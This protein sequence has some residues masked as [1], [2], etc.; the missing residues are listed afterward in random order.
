[1]EVGGRG[2]A[3]L[4]DAPAPLASAGLV[5]EP[6]PVGSVPGRERSTSNVT[7]SSSSRASLATDASPLAKE[8]P[9]AKLPVAFASPATSAT[10]I[11]RAQVVAS[12]GADASSTDVTSRRLPRNEVAGGDTNADSERDAPSGEA[13]LW[14]AF[15]GM[16]FDSGSLPAPALGAQLGG[17]LGNALELR[18]FGTYLL[19]TEATFGGSGADASRY[20]VD[21]ALVTAAL[22]GCAPRLVRPGN[23]ELGVCVGGELGVLS[24]RSDLPNGA[25][26]QTPWSALRADVGARWELAPSWLSLEARLG[27][28]VPLSRPRF[29]ASVSDE[30]GSDLGHV[31]RPSAI[32][33]RL[34]VTA[35]FA[36]DGAR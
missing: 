19:P 24:S 26:T 36:L 35:S 21:F 15:G 4:E 17:S 13:A 14:R 18:A 1:L 23:A 9:T 5:G 10:S 6:A 20:R 8:S 29:T 11:E 7:L 28:T 34:S 27:L 32:G 22:L 3:G 12:S 30:G 16:V 31:Y 33:G 25:S 2:G